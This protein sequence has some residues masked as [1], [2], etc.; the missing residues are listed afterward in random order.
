MR[1]ILSGSVSALTLSSLAILEQRSYLCCVGVTVVTILDSTIGSFLSLS[2]Q[3]FLGS[4]IGGA[5][6][7][8]N[9]TVTRAIFPVWDWSAL[10]LLC[11]LMFIQVF[12]IA[13]LKLH[14]D[15]TMAGGIVCF[16]SHR[17]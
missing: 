8:V 9:M 13:K 11:V 16:L 1:Q 2:I 15:Y 7:I 4:V 10:V 6:S 12:F 3:R 5:W 17:C 14:P